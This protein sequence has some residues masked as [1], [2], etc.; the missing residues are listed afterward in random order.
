V[1]IRLSLPL[2]PS[3]NHTYLHT[4][5]G[6][7]LTER[8]RAYRDSVAW[9]CRGLVVPA[10]GPLRLSVWLSGRGDLD[11]RLKQLQDAIALGIGFNDARIAELH[12]WRVKGSR[13]A[14]IELSWED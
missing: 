8:V 12:V 6:V 1:S 14:Q 13:G 3:V 7:V 2:P 9:Q 11:N 10:S 5:R 4:R